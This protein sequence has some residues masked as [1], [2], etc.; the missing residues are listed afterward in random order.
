MEE[1]F[2]TKIVHK[3]IELEIAFDGFCLTV[4]SSEKFFFAASVN[5]PTVSE[6]GNA[7]LLLFD[8]T[9]IAVRMEAS[10]NEPKE[11][12][13]TTDGNLG[14]CN[15]PR[16]H[17]GVIHCDTLEDGTLWSEWRSIT[18]DEDERKAERYTPIDERIKE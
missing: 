10:N 16:G 7:C 13:L 4:S 12:C 2:R 9:E 3:E 8:A 15:K 14:I 11:L 5:D 1:A 17:A 18:P 6:L